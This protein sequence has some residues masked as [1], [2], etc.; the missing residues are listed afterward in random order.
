MGLN[1][2]TKTTQTNTQQNHHFK[3][4]KDSWAFPLVNKLPQ[5][6]SPQ[7]FSIT[8]TCRQTNLD[9]M[10]LESS[11]VA[12]KLMMLKFENKCWS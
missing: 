5:L 11:N 1:C 10:Q 2:M 9:E 12:C 3:E 8:L 7:Y 6:K 4:I